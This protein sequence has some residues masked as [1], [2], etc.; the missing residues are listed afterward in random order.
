VLKEPTREG[1]LADVLACSDIEDGGQRVAVKLLKD[2][3]HKDETLRLLFDREVAALRELR[4]DNI[5]LLRDAGIDDETGRYYLAL[6]WVPHGLPSWLAAH[7]PATTE[8]FLDQVA[9]P[10]LRALAFAH[11]RKVIHRDV[12]PANVLVT[13]DGTPK[14]ADFGISKMK[15][16]LSEGSHT[17]AA[18]SSRPYAP[19]ES[20][21]KSSFSRDVF[22]YGVFLLACLTKGAIEGYDDFPAA[23]DGLEADLELVDLIEACVSLDPVDRP[24]SAPELLL[25]IEAIQRRHRVEERRV[26]T[27][28]LDLLGATRRR[29]MEEEQV[30][31]ALR[32]AINPA[33]PER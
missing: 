8:D 15:T 10:V 26:R 21:S 13:D 19:P 32:F 22:A 1:G 24:R 29:I 12:K 4:H 6:E 31:G 27:I 3:P 2:L 7:P 11:E 9:L 30:S 28:S 17:L 14:L 23:L 20:E 5:V 18:Y 16:S 33:A 25:R